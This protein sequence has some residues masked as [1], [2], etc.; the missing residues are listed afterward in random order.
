MFSVAIIVFHTS[1]FVVWNSIL[2]NY[3]A[4]D[5][6]ILSYTYPQLLYKQ[7]VR[8]IMPMKTAA[9]GAVF[10]YCRTSITH[11]TCYKFG[12]MKLIKHKGTRY[13]N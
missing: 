2:N 11:N 8:L 1:P 3:Y 7:A 4:I 13:S 12:F 5:I 10:D 6:Q 9:S